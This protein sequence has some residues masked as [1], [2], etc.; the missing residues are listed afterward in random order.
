MINEACIQAGQDVIPMFQAIKSINGQASATVSEPPSAS[1]TTRPSIT[2]QRREI[3]NQ[4]ATY[5]VS[6]VRIG[7]S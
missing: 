6:K 3:A 5:G 7:L 4:S 1:E 2:A